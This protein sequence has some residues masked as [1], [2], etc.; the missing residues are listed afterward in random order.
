MT[1]TSADGRPPSR[2]QRLAEWRWLGIGAAL[3]LAAIVTWIAI[4]GVSAVSVAAGIGLI[5]LLLVGASPVLGAGLLRGTEER[6]ARRNA[7]LERR[8]RSGR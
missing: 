6:A 8:A 5:V 7:R 1:V 3:I 4:R 2:W